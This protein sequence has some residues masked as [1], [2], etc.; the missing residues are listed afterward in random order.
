MEWLW[1]LG[2][3]WELIADARK[4]DQVW[5]TSSEKF[6]SR[7]DLEW[8]LDWMLCKKE[9]RIKIN[10]STTSESVFE[11]MKTKYHCNIFYLKKNLFFFPLTEESPQK[12]DIWTGCLNKNKWHYMTS[13]IFF[14]SRIRSSWRI[15]GV[16]VCVCWLF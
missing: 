7:K 15:R 11:L 1:M 3:M 5:L 4:P 16:C 8:T 10:L 14:K 2:W 12:P 9:Q 6:N 13:S